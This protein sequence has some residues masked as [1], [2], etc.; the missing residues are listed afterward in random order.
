MANEVQVF[1]NE[2]FGSIRTIEDNGKVLFCGADVAKALGYSNTR[3]AINRHCKPEGVAK[4]DGVVQTTNQYGVTSEQTVEMKFINEGNV[5][6]LIVHS[7]LPNAERFESWVFDEV[8]PSL[9]KTGTYTVPEKPDSYMIE[10]PAAR[11]RRWA[12]EYEEKAELMVKLEEQKPLV[13]YA[14]HIKESKDVINMASMAKIASKHGIKIGRNSLFAFLRGHKILDKENL[15][16]A[17]YMNRDWFEVKETAHTCL[18]GEVKLNRTTL[19][20][21]N[22]QIGIINLLKRDY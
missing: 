9:R 10:D 22:G 16:Y 14:E 7:K 21:P 20:T 19:V 18:S 3:D 8:L 4:R 17:A 15:P 11:A 5:Y 1:N 6:R 13:D 2:Q 12:E